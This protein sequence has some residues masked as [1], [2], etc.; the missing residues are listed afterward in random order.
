M[1]RPN[2]TTHTYTV[3]QTSLDKASVVTGALILLLQARPVLPFLQVQPGLWPTSPWWTAPPLDSSTASFNAASPPH[4]LPFSLEQGLLISQSINSFICSFSH[5]LCAFSP[6]LR[7][8]LWIGSR[9]M[10]ICLLQDHIST[11]PML[12]SA[13]R[14]I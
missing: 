1:D 2:R 8:K 11:N 7:K 14:G 3:G 13:T 9:T 4:L 10:E 6:T 5:S 12:S